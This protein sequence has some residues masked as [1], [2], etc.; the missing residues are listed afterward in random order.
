M[1]STVSL[2]H[3]VIALLDVGTSDIVISSDS[4]EERFIY[5]ASTL[6][7]NEVCARECRQGGLG[8]DEY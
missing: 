5:L 2:N 1:S 6:Q 8:G 7:S 3:N 4:M